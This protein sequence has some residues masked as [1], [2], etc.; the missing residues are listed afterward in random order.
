MSMRRIAALF[1]VLVASALTACS[2]GSNNPAQNGPLPQTRSVTNYPI[3]P[4]PADG[5]A[6]L[7]RGVRARGGHIIGIRGNGGNAVPMLFCSPTPPPPPQG[8]PV[9]YGHGN[10][11]ISAQHYNVYVNC[12]STCWGSPDPG[13]YFGGLE[14][15]PFM[16]L[17]DQY[18]P[19]TPGGAFGNGL[20]NRYA[21]GG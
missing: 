1:T 6:T 7:P 10:L 19:A 18:V 12:A 15:T 13:A 20:P 21:F 8:S 5:I 3:C 9:Y 14:S 4:P 16:H 11:V 2:G 17:I